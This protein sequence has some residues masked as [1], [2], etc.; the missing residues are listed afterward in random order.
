MRKGSITLTEDEKLPQEP[1]DSGAEEI[2]QEPL[3]GARL[4]S[5]IE[6]LLF[7]SP[8][9]LPRDRLNK[10]L[11]EVAKE[12]LENALLELEA[13]LVSGVRGFTLV[14]EAAGLRLLTRS[15]FAPFVARLRGDGRRVRLSQAAFETLAFIA[16]K[17]PVRRADLDAVRGVQSSGTLKNLMEWNLV[18]IT[19]REDTLGKPLLYGTTD[20]FLEQFGF[21]SLA[22]L[23]DPE[24]LLELGGERGVEVMSAED[25]G[26]ETPAV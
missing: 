23:P 25:E 8:E 24:R 26:R 11:R 18:R 4:R 6:A 2:P 13:D 1:A 5:C 20:F 3:E 15:E 17:Q 16:Y 7:A 19:G 22:D 21:E 12:D 9:P 14:R 10:I